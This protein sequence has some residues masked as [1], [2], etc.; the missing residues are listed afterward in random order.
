[1]KAVAGLVVATL[2]AGCGAGTPPSRFYMLEP[3]TPAESVAS[4]G[5]RILVDRP[6]IARHL[7]RPQLVRRVDEL[8]ITFT[9]F[10]TWAEPLDDLLARA[11]VDGLAARFG[12]DRVQVTPAAR[13]AGADVRLGLDVLRFDTDP[14]NAIV[15]DARWTLLAG[16]DERFAGTG[17][18]RIVE[19]V[20]EPVTPE[21]RVAASSRA[22]QRLVEAL[23][24][25]IE[26]AARQR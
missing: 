7:D 13:D 4:S 20:P 17:R 25:A 11:L 6:S 2:L 26:R 21:A 14:A 12:R 5:P 8:Q 22:V 16:A 1:M 19:P 23:T 9:D 10:D 15:L 3:A 24:P 18:E